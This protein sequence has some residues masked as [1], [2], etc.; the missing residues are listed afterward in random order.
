MLNINDVTS[1]ANLSQITP[2]SYI[3]VDDNGCVG[4]PYSRGV[5]ASA[6]RSGRKWIGYQNGENL[7]RIRQLFTRSLYAL[8]S[9]ETDL[10]E[11]IERAAVGFANLEKTYS[12]KPEIQ[13]EIQNIV[14]EVLG[15]LEV[16]KVKCQ[17]TRPPEE[18]KR[19]RELETSQFISEAAVDA[20]EGYG[21]L[22]EK[23]E[24]FLM[25]EKKLTAEEREILR[26]IQIQIK[27]IHKWIF[28]KKG[29]FSEEDSKLTC[30]EILK[31]NKAYFREYLN[32]LEQMDEETQ[33]NLGLLIPISYLYRDEKK[34]GGHEAP[35]GLCKE[36]DGTY[37]LISVNAGEEHPGSIS[38]VTSQLSWA[39]PLIFH[40]ET[41]VEFGPLSQ[42]EARSFLNKAYETPLRFNSR[43]EAIT[44]YREFFT[45][46]IPRKKSQRIPFRRMQVTGN[47]GT[48]NPLEWMLF[49]LQKYGKTDLANRFLE[50]SPLRTRSIS[51]EMEK[52]KPLVKFC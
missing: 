10:R 18:L 28:V 50:Y 48:K 30:G 1:L 38:K 13:Q 36:V 17:K 40:G 26:K 12:H 15:Q 33:K 32:L 11:K 22:E 51:P 4:V 2:S 14:Q 45:P 7:P 8:C 39:R 49:S 16:V 24:T 44:A 19:R 37:T 25:L 21:W 5:I 42:E 27:A 41:V 47:C 43:E 23:I 6:W 20:S 31:R 35:F 29:N 9:G 34:N 46:F 52:V 3:D